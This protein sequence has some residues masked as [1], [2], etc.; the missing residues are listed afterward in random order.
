MCASLI[1]CFLTHFDYG[2]RSD[3][4]IGDHLKKVALY[5]NPAYFIGRFFYEFIFF[6]VVIVI[7]LGVV[8]GIIIDTFAELNEKTV[9]IEHDM[10]NVC[11]I[12]GAKKDELEKEC[13]N[14]DEHIQNDHNIW[15]YALYIIGLKFVDPQETNA[16]NS[17]VI[18]MNEERSISWLPSRVVNHH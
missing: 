3:S 18:E 2:V 5:D 14:Y 15:N 4:G 12:C 7:M 17:Y 8:F 9:H 16:I 10:K 13:I 6:I 1:S 11:F